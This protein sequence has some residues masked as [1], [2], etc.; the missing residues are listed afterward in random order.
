MHVAAKLTSKGQITV[1]KSV[2]DAL[3]LEPG[4]NVLFRIDGAHAVLARTADFLELAGSV[5]VP[6]S[7]RDASWE[8][9]RD[10][11]RRARGKARS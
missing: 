5:A 1:P 2:R 6:A 8:T 9:I 4:D 7:K 10:E 3:D 11:T